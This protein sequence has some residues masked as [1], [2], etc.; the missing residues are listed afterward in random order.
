MDR[1]DFVLNIIDV[2]TDDNP[3][4]NPSLV[5]NTLNIN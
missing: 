4:T 2:L 3:I 1:E 5:K